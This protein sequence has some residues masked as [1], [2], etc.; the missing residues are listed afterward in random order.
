MTVNAVENYVQGLLDGLT[1]PQFAAPTQA[2]V[3]PPPVVMLA[4]NPQVFVWGGTWHEERHTLPRILGDKRITYSL[5]V[6]LQ[7]ATSNDPND[8]YGP[9][10][11]PI[12]IETI[13]GVLRTTPIPAA[14]I[15][16]DTGIASIVQTIGEKI[17]FA[18]PPPVASEDQRTLWHV[19]TL[20]LYI[21]EE[22]SPG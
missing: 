12:L 15:D 17:D 16:P 4:P 11:F 20:K 14:I 19:A 18:H 7:A 22:L 21:V 9:T 5:S 6:W 3:L 10:A 2:Y 1:V 13:A 8:E